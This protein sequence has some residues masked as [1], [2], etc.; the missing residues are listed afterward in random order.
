MDFTLAV[1]RSYG[2]SDYIP[3]IAWG[4]L[5][6]Y[7]VANVAIGDKIRAIGRLQSREYKKVWEDGT[8]EML[9][10]YEVSLGRLEKLPKDQRT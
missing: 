6:D 8:T 4:R 7:I 9:T 5:A 2:K 10:A 1:H 3:C